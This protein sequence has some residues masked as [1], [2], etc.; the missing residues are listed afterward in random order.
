M[1]R[2]YTLA[3]VAAAILAMAGVGT[4]AYFSDTEQ[5]TANTFTAGTLNLKLSDSDQ[6]DQDGVSA[7]FGASN[8]APGDVIPLGT[9]TL[10]NTGTIAADH[11]DIKFTCSD[12][13]YSLAAQVQTDTGDADIDLST[14]LEVT[15]LS[16]NG[17]D[18]LVKDGDGY[19]VDT[20]IGLADGNG[21]GR[22][23]MSELN[24]TILKGKAAPAANGASTI[25]LTIGLTIRLDA[26]NGIQG[27]QVTITITFGLFQDASQNLT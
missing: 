20:Q 3:I 26:N 15:S 24:N 5:S 13:P 6:T 18:L 10:K 9:I 12:T 19:F 8:R 23:M 22:L 25:S 7:T 21:D 1:K 17:T 11:V 14:K 2:I 27:D 16:Y 4:W